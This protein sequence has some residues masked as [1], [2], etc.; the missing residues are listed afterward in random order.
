MV[1]NFID[2]DLQNQ[3]GSLPWPTTLSVVLGDPGTHE[4]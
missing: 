2:T 1:A 4:E 3:K